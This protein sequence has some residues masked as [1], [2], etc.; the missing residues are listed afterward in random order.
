M[1]ISLI[2]Y[3]IAD[4]KEQFVPTYIMGK[5]NIVPLYLGKVPG[6]GKFS[7][8]QVAIYV[9]SEDYNKIDHT[10]EYVLIHDPIVTEEDFKE[11]KENISK[12]IRDVADIKS[13]N[14]VHMHIGRQSNYD[15]VPNIQGNC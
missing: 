9:K 1:E 2:L 15:I 4:W 11:I 14:R 13:A 7:F 12:V 5:E 3:D 8:N 6:V 10:K